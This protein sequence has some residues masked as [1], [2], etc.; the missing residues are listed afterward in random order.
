MRRGESITL[1]V[2]VVVFFGLAVT[3]WGAMPPPPVNQNL[4]LGDTVFNQMEEADCRFC[5]NQ[6]PPQP[7]PVDPTYLPD[8]HHLLVG[9]S[10][11]PGS[12]VPNPDADGVPGADTTYDCLNCH[13][14]VWDPDLGSY[15]IVEDFRDCTTCH[16]Q[17]AG[18]STVHH[19]TAEALEGNCQYCHGAFVDR[20]LFDNDGDGIAETVNA[21][22]VPTYQPSLVTPW[23]S[24]K[25]I[26]GTCSGPLP[27]D[28]CVVDGDCP[29]GETCIPDST[30]DP[31]DL[32]GTCST[33][34]SQIC[35]E[36]GDCP[37]TETCNWPDGIADASSAGTYA[38]NCNFCHNTATGGPGSP[39]EENTGPFDP[40]LVFRNDETHHSTDFYGGGYC[41]WCHLTIP[42]SLGGSLNIRTCETCHGMPSLHNIQFAGQEPG[43]PSDGTVTP[44]AEMPWSG[45]IG[46]QIDCNG[47]HGFDNVTIERAFAPQ[48]GPVI[49]GLYTTSASSVESGASV[50]LNGTAFI[51]L[52]QNPMTGEYDE[53]LDS[54]VVLTGADG[55]ETLIAPDSITGDTIHVTLTGV[56]PGS[57]KLALKKTLK[58]SNPINLAITPN[59]TIDSASC[60]DGVVTIAG[61]GF[62]AYLDASN[63]GTSVSATVT[64]TTG[65]GKNKTTVTET[66]NGEVSS[67]RDTEIVATFASCPAS[68]DVATVF[69]QATATVGGSSSGGACSDHTDEDS[70]TADAACTWSPKKGGSCQD[71]G[72]GG[73]GKNK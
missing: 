55:S 58:K 38:G 33:T 56:A 15:V 53:T 16:V 36:A 17:N 61:S 72:G 18:E 68:V 25:D 3:A 54:D 14:I 41:N 13:N 51:N 47:C 40:I 45:H 1:T 43:V 62:G 12:E 63:S 48:S 69:D 24:R 6:N 2:L 60:A 22:W 5:H 30:P 64:T 23:P 21:P 46:N 65:K 50:E 49:P 8:R 73:G 26:A 29:T 27:Q 10:I 71:A 9:T 42:P 52:V 11:P 44:G 34:T 35:R 28:V 59:A 7:Y 20:G 37:G 31:V 66:V 4:G 32:Y 70:C 57:Y 39:T 19:R 67:W